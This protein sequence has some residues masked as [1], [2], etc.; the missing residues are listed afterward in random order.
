MVYWYMPWFMILRQK[1]MGSSK[2]LTCNLR[3]SLFGGCKYLCEYLRENE[4]IFEN[5]LGCC[6]GAYVGSIDS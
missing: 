2:N 5:I 3:V 4:T 6:S 1:E